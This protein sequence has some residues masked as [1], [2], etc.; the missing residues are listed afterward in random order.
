MR[1]VLFAALLPM[2]AGAQPCTTCRVDFPADAGAINVRS[3]GATGDG[4]TDDTKAL[5]AAIAASGG[6][7]GSKFWKD[8][9]VFLPDGTYL[10]S[11]PLLKK[12]ANGGFASG[13]MLQGE[14]VYGTV[15]KLADAA[16]GYDNPARQ[17]AILYTAARLIDQGG[18]YGG[19]K[20]YPGRGEGNDAYENFA[21][22][23]TID[24]GTHNPGAI[25]IDF[26]ANNI[27]AIRN[28]VLRAPPGSG[29]VA[30]ALQR[31][32]P[33]PALIS[34][35]TVEGF[36]TAIAAAQTEY[37]VTLQHLHLLNQGGP[38]IVNAGNVLSLRD[39]HIAGSPQPL[40]NIGATALV[41]WHGG[42]ITPGAESGSDAARN[43][44]TIA[45]RGVAIRGYATIAGA[46]ADAAEAGLA[47]GPNGRLPAPTWRVP[48]VDP[49]PMPRDPPSGWARVSPDQSDAT[50]AI[51]AAFNS[52]SATAYF[53]HGTYFISSAIE[54]PPTLRRIV[55]MNSTIRIVPERAQPFSR[56]SGMFRVL[57]PGLPLTIEKLAFDNSDLGNQIAVESGAQRSLLLRDIVSAGTTL[58]S[59]RPEGGPL[60]L[61]DVC[62][63]DMEFSGRAPVYASQLDTEGAG[64]RI[65]VNGSPVSILGLKTEGIATVLSASNNAHADIIG[66]L[67]YMVQPSPAPPPAF[68]LDQ[69]SLAATYAEEVL[70]PGARYTIH[71]AAPSRA[72]PAAALP[73][74]GLGR[75]ATNLQ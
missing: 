73:S 37:G 10:V 30:I 71:L 64:V 17:R 75:V 26:L 50:A 7:T 46:P 58:V 53:P 39:V 48:V 66:G 55:G 60:F 44:G 62:C 2:V 13:L 63:G 1:A 15:I 16:P 41:A 8:R 68:T 12:Y 27:G 35:V 29:A 21:E 59:R 72:V 22:N 34:G 52:G 6:F 14:S 45:L 57:Q 32:W 49:P 24:A 56:A 69:A 18:P 4:H 70:Q 19:G 11:A 42:D 20:D 74:R 61:E 5:L 38:A 40:I 3:F 65:R 54:I 31:K 51:R 43:T 25:A 23:M 47:R 9:P 67:L 36:T 28:V 33:G